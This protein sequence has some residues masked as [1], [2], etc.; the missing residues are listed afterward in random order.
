M[1]L[2]VGQALVSAVDTTNIIVTKAPAGDIELTCGG[3]AMAAKG[4]AVERCEPNLAFMKGS[5]LGKRYVNADGTLE[6]LVTKAGE[7]SL[8]VAGELLTVAGAK[9]LPASD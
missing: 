9:A 2:R 3:A 4:A 5:L 8:A 6:L 7:F 1:E